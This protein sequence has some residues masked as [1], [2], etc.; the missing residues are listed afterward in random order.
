MA[1]P[2]NQGQVSTPV[3]PVS[4]KRRREASRPRSFP[5]EAAAPVSHPARATGQKRPFWGRPAVRPPVPKLLEEWRC[6][7]LSARKV[8]LAV[9]R[10]ERL[11]LGRTNRL[12]SAFPT[13]ARHHTARG[14]LHAA[15][16][17]ARGKWTPRVGGAPGGMLDFF[18]AIFYMD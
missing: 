11:L 16:W 18:F 13:R 4:E 12:G 15:F 8:N 6:F 10:A 2:Q 3:P 14:A 9:A 17:C 5:F 1:A 7:P